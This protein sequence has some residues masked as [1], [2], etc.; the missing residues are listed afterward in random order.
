MD[1]KLRAI[2]CNCSRVLLDAYKSYCYS[3]GVTIGGSIEALI[4]QHLRDAG[5]EVPFTPQIQSIKMG[6]LRS[7]KRSA[8]ASDV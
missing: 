8:E 4:E 2:G 5:I 7:G 6:M 3:N 1:P